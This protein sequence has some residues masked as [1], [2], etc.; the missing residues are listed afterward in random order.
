MMDGKK[1]LAGVVGKKQPLS[2]VARDYDGDGYV[3]P[4]DCKPFDKNKQGRIHDA[5]V[6]LRDKAKEKFNEFSE[7]R[8]E[9]REKEREFRT[10]AKVKEKEA[11]LTERKKVL[12]NQAVQRG[13]ARA[14]KPTFSAN[15]NRFAN[16]IAQ[17]QSV[18]GGGSSRGSSNLSQ[19]KMNFDNIL[20][21]SPKKKTGKT[22]FDIKI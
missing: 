8:K 12:D 2:K 19:R 5:A 14:N 4:I 17:S 18:L 15:L 10:E 3:D 7:E 20:G 9:R 6:A 1:V 16:N 11:F 13:K 22:I 21:G